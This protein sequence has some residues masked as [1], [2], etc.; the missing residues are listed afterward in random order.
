M[1]CKSFRGLLA[2]ASF[3]NW[4]KGKILDRDVIIHSLLEPPEGGVPVSTIAIIVYYR[5][6]SSWDKDPSEP[7]LTAPVHTEPEPHVKASEMV[8]TA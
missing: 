1:R 7:V 3:N 8:V 5:E 4:A 6:G 2:Q